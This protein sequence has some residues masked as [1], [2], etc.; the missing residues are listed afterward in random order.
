MNANT[1]RVM[2]FGCQ[3]I[4]IDVIDFVNKCTFTGANEDGYVFL[5]TFQRR[6]MQMVLTST[7]GG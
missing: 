7:K 1:V 3:K 2:V 4:A 6:E 5:N